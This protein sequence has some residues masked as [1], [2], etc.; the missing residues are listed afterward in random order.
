MVQ[1]D[2]IKFLEREYHKDSE[3]T[4][5][6]R[7]I[8]NGLKGNIKDHSLRSL[9]KYGEISRELEEVSMNGCGFRQFRYRYVPN[10]PFKIISFRRSD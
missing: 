2:V 10:G 1:A 6:K 8:E 9:V 3:R 4:F 7:E 5:T